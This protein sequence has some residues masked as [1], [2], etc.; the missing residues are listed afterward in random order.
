[1]ARQLEDCRAL[2]RSRG[3]EATEFCD[4]DIS[5]SRFSERPRPAYRAMLDAVHAGVI[6][7]IVVW[8]T[9]RLYRQPRELEELLDLAE[10]RVNQLEVVSVQSGALDLNSTDGRLVARVM[11]AVSAQESDHKS[12]RVKRAKAQAR[13]RGRPSGGVRAFGWR[14]GLTP[15]PREAEL[16]SRAADHILAGGSMMD[17]AREWIALKMQRPQSGRSN[18]TA[19]TVHQVLTNPRNAGLVAHRQRIATPN[20]RH[21]RYEPP[22]ILEGVAAAWPAIIERERWERLQAVLER[23]GAG[24]RVPRRGSLL[25]GFLRCGIC[26]SRMVRTGARANTKGETHAWRCPTYSGCGRVSIS[27]EPVEEVLVAVVLARLDSEVLPAADTG[28][29]ALLDELRRAESDQVAALKSLEEGRIDFAMFERVSTALE[30]RRADLERKIRVNPRPALPFDEPGAVRQ[31]WP[32]LTIDQRRAILAE[33]VEKVSIA[34][35][36]R[37]YPRF[38]PSRLTTTWRA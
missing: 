15:E 23:R 12:D 10:G 25:T 29:A 1:M 13:E 28:D 31:V 37:G 22:R 33:F 9:D 4:N 20:G 38:D 17:I 8:H 27:A 34:P 2:A 21:A 32:E 19:E 5:A 35:S 26:G 6:G 24:N 36:R 18:W 7:R 14:D 16:L 11:V 30:R 3:W